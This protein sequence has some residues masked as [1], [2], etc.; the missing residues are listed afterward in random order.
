MRIHPRVD[1]VD[2]RLPSFLMVVPT[3]SRL[4]Q[5]T[6][7][8]QSLTHLDYA[9]NH[10]EVIVVGDGSDMAPNNIVSSF[11]HP[12]TVRLIIQ[13]HCDPATARNIGAKE[14]PDHAPGDQTL[15]ASQNNLYS[16]ASQLIINYL[17]AYYN[18]KPHQARFFTSNNFALP[19]HLFRSI[20]GFSSTF[21]HAAGE[22]RE[23]CERCRHPV[24]IH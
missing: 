13:P 17:Y 14:T 21:P 15:N 19:A 1:K 16:R 2:Q 10:F 22:D 4:I 11:C 18:A 8:L 3:F 20:G 23:F 12:L 5:L 7:Y 6:A 9:K 24:L